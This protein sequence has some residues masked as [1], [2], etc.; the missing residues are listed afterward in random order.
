MPRPTPKRSATSL[1]ARLKHRLAASLST[2]KS[3]IRSKRASA[4]APAHG[5][6]TTRAATRRPAAR[7]RS[8]RLAPSQRGPRKFPRFTTAR[9]AV[10][11]PPLGATAPSTA[12]PLMTTADAV[13]PATAIVSPAPRTALPQ[14][15]GETQL[16]LLI[17]DP[18][19]LYAFWE[20]TPARAAEAH[21]MLSPQERAQ[22]HTVLRLYDVT[23]READVARA[24]RLLDI[25]LTHDVD[26][27]FVDT[28]EAHRTWVA[29]LGY[30]T[31]QGRFVPLVRS[32][33][34][35]TPRA[36]PSDLFDEAWMTTDEDYWKLLGVMYGLGFGTSSF[37]IREL[38]ERRFRDVISSAG[39]S[40]GA[41]A[42][43]VAPAAPR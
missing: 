10:G 17:R 40:S 29:E 38:L 19:W 27:W 14:R 30:R 22:H 11:A 23:D 4:T 32:N 13:T 1:K 31:A 39:R 6:M 7:A 5:A 28:G 37:E 12:P 3:R 18:W 33:V 20:I 34:V 26:N 43:G 35:T 16:T 42:V 15:Y 25:V 41:H 9:P 8:P 2:A 24:H 36:G 21:A